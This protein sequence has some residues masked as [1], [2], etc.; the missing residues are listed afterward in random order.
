MRWFLLAALTFLITV[1]SSS[2]HFVFLVPD[3]AGKAKAVFSDEL[4]P[5]P[6]VPI[7]KAANTKLYLVVGDK[8]TELKWNLNKEGNFYSIETGTKEDS[9]V[10]GTTDYGIFQRGDNPP[11][12]LLYHPKVVF[13]ELG[14]AALLGDKVPLEI[15]P[16]LEAGKIRFQV[17]LAGKPLEKADVKVMVPSEDKTEAVT[18]DAKGLTPTFE[19]KGEYG[20]YAKFIEMKGG[21]I[22]GKKFEQTSHYATLVVTFGK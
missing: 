20:V 4:K 11:Q 19:K 15:V 2:A 17:L 14:K 18:T 21:E 12:R 1:G 9:T 6:K 13:G 5:D 22:D 16:I 10:G 7:E 8:K 3:G